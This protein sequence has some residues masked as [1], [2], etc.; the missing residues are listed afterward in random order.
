[1]TMLVL[2]AV[3]FLALHLVVS[4]SP[5]RGVIVG[6][7]GEAAF[8]GLFSLLSAGGIV[9]LAATYG[10]ARSSPE[11]TVWWGVTDATRHAQFVLQV[12]ALLLIVPGLL[13]ANPTSVKQEGALNREDVVKGMLRI[14]RHPFLWGVA[15]LS[16]GHLM[17]NGDAAS[18]VLFGTLLF[19]A[20]SGTVSIDAKRKAAL[21]DGWTPFAQATSNVPFAAILTGRQP[22]RLGEIGL[23]KLGAAV[24]VYVALGFAHPYLFGVAVTG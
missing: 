22:L 16:V 13:T 9:L 7:I 4:G 8:L 11:N 14:T 15:V 23:V 18:L 19:L 12:L 5:L 2:A 17:V 10:M 21:G 3:A 1:M 6:R 20:L 24:A